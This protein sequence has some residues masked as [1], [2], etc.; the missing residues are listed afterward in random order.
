MGSNKMKYDVITLREH[1]NEKYKDDFTFLNFIYKEKRINVEY[2]CNK[3]LDNKKTNYWNLLNPKRHI[4]CRVC[5]P[6][7]KKLT[8]EDFIN[9]AKNVHGDLYNYDNTL[10]VDARTKVTIQ[11]TKCQ[12]I[13]QQRTTA[14]LYNRSGCPKCKFSQGEQYIQKF[15]TSHNIEYI[16]Q[17]IFKDLKGVGGGYVKFDFFLPKENMCIEYDGKQHTD[18]KSRYWSETIVLNDTIKNLYC[19]KNKI[20]LLRISYL[21]KDRIEEIISSILAIAPNP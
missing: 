9:I 15:L 13:F 7:I 14:H 17:K 19:D 10:Y 18:M 16:S 3:C 8:T 12:Y 20:K 5:F 11:C 21:D 6:D 4:K 2:V 1:L